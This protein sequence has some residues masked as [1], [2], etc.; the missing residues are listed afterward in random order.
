M[1]TLKD[2]LQEE[3][4]EEFL[5]KCYVDFKYWA[6]RVFGYV[7][8]PEHLEW[9]NAIRSNRRVAI[10]APT[11]FGKTTILGNCYALWL[12][13]F[14]PGSQ[15]LIV[16]S[17]LNQAAKILEEI[18][19]EIE[20]NELLMNL[21][22]DNSLVKSWTQVKVILRGN[23]KIFCCPL[24]P[25]IKG[26]HVDYV[27]ADEA[28]EYLDRELYHRYL[29]T[30]TNSK[31][32]TVCC[33][34]TPVGPGDL[35]QELIHNP[36]YWGKSYPAIVKGDSWFPEKFPMS[37]LER[38]KRENPVAFD[39][40]YILNPKA[41]IDCALFQP[42]KVMECFDYDATFNL[43]D[44]G[45]YKVLACD[46]AIASGKRADFDA[47]VVVEKVGD[48]NMLRHGERHKGFPVASKV[49]RI[50]QLYENYKPEKIL[51]DRSQVGHA[52]IEECRK[53][54]LPIEGIDF[55]S[56]N[57]N[58]MLVNLQMVIDEERLV[59]PRNSNDVAAMTFTTILVDEL[60]QMQETRTKLG[61]RTYVSRGAH[62][63]TVM[64][65]AMA[66]S[67][68]LAQR[69]FLDCVAL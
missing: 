48:R 16:S 13:W 58:L 53:L 7:V 51:V 45:G 8:K 11:G 50:K 20:G 63:D 66:I 43:Q 4:M 27:L 24:T 2:I 22:P 56:A 39:R 62:D 5:L 47:Y 25:S 37:E 28:A 42:A 54:M 6:E 18:R 59:I 35:M 32:G 31:K 9:V 65:L 40:E 3:D 14:K 33:I 17:R 64:A 57:R 26:Y 61:N 29:V 23:S 68:T 1:R 52:V 55:S 15:V 41:E 19:M 36:E 34:S 49:L 21:L 44:E 69:E 60:I 38:I 67:G 12:M 30:R 46:F 10:L